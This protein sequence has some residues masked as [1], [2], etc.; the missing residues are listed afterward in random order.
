MAAP[1]RG[2]HRVRKSNAGG[3]AEYWYAWRSGPLILSQSA[4]TDRLLDMKVAA[5]AEDAGR[6]YFALHA[7]R[8]APPRDTLAALIQAWRGVGDGPGSPEF[9]KLAERTRKD[10]KRHLAVIEAD[11][12]DMPLA[13]LK[14]DSARKALLEWRNRYSDRPRTADHYA[15]ALSQLLLWARDQGHTSAD[16]MRA[17]PWIYEVDRAGI[18]WTAQEIEAVCACAEPE[19]QRAILLAAYSGL[20]QGDLIKL[21]WSAIGEGVI[22]RK[23]NKRGRVVYIPIKPPLRAALAS[24]P[25]VGPIILT[26]DGQPWKAS[27]LQKRWRIAR[28]QAIKAC[29]SIAG[30]RW[31]DFRGSFATLLIRDGA[32]DADVDRIMGWKPGNSELTRASYVTGSVIAEVTLKRLKPGG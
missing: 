30:K 22:I 11:I 25:Q 5:A 17:W 14:A 6:Q 3:R 4:T 9:Q 12:G 26:K 20:R 7:A 2:V 28:A 31:H 1:L 32:E 24:C 8:K 16:P 10:L 13:A 21:P 29:P 23:T 27:T 19:L 15:S 18:V